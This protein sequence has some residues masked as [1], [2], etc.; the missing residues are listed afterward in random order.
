MTAQLTPWK[1]IASDLRGFGANQTAVAGTT[2]ETYADDMVAVLDELNLQQSVFCGLSMGGYVVLDIWRRYPERVRALVLANT[3]PGADTE[4]AQKG[5][6][7]MTAM[8]Q[9]DG[10]QSLAEL[11][12]PKLLAPTSLT[13]KPD[14]VAD[15][16]AMI[17]ESSVGGVVA[18]LHAMKHRRDSTPLLE[19]IAVPTLVLAGSE[20]MLMP[21][22]E[23]KVMADTIPGAQYAVMS[24]TGHLSPMEEPNDTAEVIGHFLNAII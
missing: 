12:V 19:G 20:D 15:L 8:V 3:R 17:S 16:R 9:N 24:G 23:V 5:R 4:A 10:V 22:R 6:D 21:A 13:T 14:V 1:C 7:E 11:M 2:I 18:A